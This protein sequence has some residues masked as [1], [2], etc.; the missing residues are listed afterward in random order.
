MRMPFQKQD[1]CHLILKPGL[2]GVPNKHDSSFSLPNVAG[3]TNPLS[4]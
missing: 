4:W 1:F 2:D 3:K